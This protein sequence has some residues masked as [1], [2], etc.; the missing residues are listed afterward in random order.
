MTLDE[1]LE[2]TSER[3]PNAQE[4]V[5]LCE[6]VGIQFA[7]KDSVPVLRAKWTTETRLIGELVSK[8]I[9]REPWRSQVLSTIRVCGVCGE[10]LKREDDWT[11]C[12]KCEGD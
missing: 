1:F 2:L 9:G 12:P 6:T 5:G 10:E 7:L 11:F 8:L 4:L 3:L